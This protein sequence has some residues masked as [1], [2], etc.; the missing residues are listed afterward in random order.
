MVSGK[1]IHLFIEVDWLFHAYFQED[2]NYKQAFI[3][4]YVH[5]RIF[6][7]LMMKLETHSHTLPAQQPFPM[8][9]EKI[10]RPWI[11][12]RW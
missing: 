2:S 12:S 10:T 8:N 11:S 6:F 4:L 7:A 3:L 5:K 9:I 1:Y